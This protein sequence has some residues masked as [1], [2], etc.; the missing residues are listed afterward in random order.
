[1]ALEVWK[2]M[3]KKQ[4]APLYLLYGP[5]PF[6]IKKTLSTLMENALEESEVE[7]NVSNFDLEET[8]IHIALEE[9][10]T[11]P[12]MGER[13][14][15][16]LHNPYFLTA[17]KTKEKVEH[18]IQLFLDYVENPSP[19]S[20]VVIAAPY[21]KL[22][23]RKKITK[24]LKKYAT[25]VEANKLKDQELIK[26]IEGQAA[27]HGVQIERD[28]I[29]ALMETAGQNL[30]LLSNEIEK[31]ALYVFEEKVITV[32]TVNDL[33]SKSLEQNIFTLIDFIMN[34]KASQAIQLLQ[35]LLRQNEEPIKVLALMASQVRIM[36]VA[37]SLAQNGYG[38]QKIATHLKIH[39]F[40]V[41]LALEKARYFHEKELMTFLNNIADADYKMKTGQMDKALLLE[42]IILQSGSRVNNR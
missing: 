31:M 18:N 23:E 10:E 33:A 22:D 28:A 24:Q 26:W 36:Y 12:F 15:V 29:Q 30:L 1:M 9:A 40:R 11:F 17:E 35:S 37:K 39:P 41:K 16:I 7:F 8:P 42:L 13:K 3:K 21:E 2:Q 27:T 14:L 4:F 6:I 19:F 25:V 34:R 38:Q 32:Q 20:I 5:E